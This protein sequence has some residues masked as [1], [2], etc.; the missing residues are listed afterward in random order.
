MYTSQESVRGFYLRC[1]DF[2][3]LLNNID[4]NSSDTSTSIPDNLIA[5][6]VAVYTTL[7]L[8]Y[9]ENIH[10]P[11]IYAWCIEAF[12]DIPFYVDISTSTSETQQFFIEVDIV[13]IV[14]SAWV[15]QGPINNSRLSVQ[16]TAVHN[17]AKAVLGTAQNRYTNYLKL[18]RHSPKSS[19]RVNKAWESRAFEHNQ[20]VSSWECLAMNHGYTLG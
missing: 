15:L 12:G 4:F 9:S 10:L 6:K 20:L 2:S 19:A 18:T 16:T 3:K 13:T 5:G 1:Q 17:I 8:I 11:D 7:P 14:P